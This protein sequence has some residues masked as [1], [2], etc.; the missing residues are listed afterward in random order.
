MFGYKLV[1]EKDYKHLLRCQEVDRRV[2]ELSRWLK[3][4]SVVYGGVFNYLI[5]GASNVSTAREKILSDLNYFQSL[6]YDKR[7]DFVKGATK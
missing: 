2:V 5:F 6:S 3:P 7:K 4:W 1:S